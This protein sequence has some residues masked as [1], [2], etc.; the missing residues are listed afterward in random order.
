[1]YMV[2]LGDKKYYIEVTDELAAIRRVEAEFDDLPDFDDEDESAENICNVSATL[3]G[4][5][6]HVVAQIGQRVEKDSVLFL[7]ETMKMELELRAP[8]A[9]VVTQID[10]AVGQHVEKGQH[11]AQIQTES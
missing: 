4:N 3:P 10:V 11:L 7:C 2:Q 5:I 8:V 9:G 1:M 6:C